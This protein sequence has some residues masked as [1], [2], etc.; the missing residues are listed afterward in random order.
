MAA[1]SR[2]LPSNPRSVCHGQVIPVKTPAYR[3]CKTTR[4]NPPAFAS[5]RSLLR[6]H[7]LAACLAGDSC[8]GPGMPRAGLASTARQDGLQAS[9]ESGTAARTLE[10]GE[11]T[12]PRSRFRGAAAQAR[13]DGSQPRE[14]VRHLLRGGGSSPGATVSCV[15]LS[16]GGT[17]H[18]PCLRGWV[19]PGVN[20][21]SWPAFFL[22]V[23]T[24]SFAKAPQTVS[25]R[26]ARFQLTV[27]Q[28]LLLVWQCVKA[29]PRGV[30]VSSGLALARPMPT[31]G[32]RRLTQAPGPGLWVRVLLDT[33]RREGAHG[34]CPPL[35]PTSPWKPTECCHVTV[36]C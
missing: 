2:L 35:L 1:V 34:L 30:L 10:R 17:P 6:K 5:C 18:H 32:S 24:V 3:T 7:L 26:S 12:V 19:S 11:V 16:K 13:W 23:S 20:G 14:C 33:R 15:V 36:N 29:I 31:V 8:P 25:E 27:L 21:T 22:L 28:V 4:V 9:P